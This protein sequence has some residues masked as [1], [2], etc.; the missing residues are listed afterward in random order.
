M[1]TLYW[2]IALALC[3]LITACKPEPSPPAGAYE[4]GVFGVNEG[5]FG[6]SSGTISYYNP[7]T[8]ENQGDIFRTQNGRFLGDVVQSLCFWG[9]QAYILVNNSQ[10]IEVVEANSFKEQA[11]VRGLYLPRYLC[12]INDS[13]AYISQWG[14]DGL[15]GSL[16]L[17]HKTQGL[18]DS[19]PLYQGPERL[20]YR[21]GRLYVLHAGGYDR[22]DKLAVLNTQ[23]QSLAAL[24]TPGENPNSLVFEPSGASFWLLCAGYTRYTTYPAIDTQASRP[25]RLLRMDAQTGQIYFSKDLPLGSPAK[26]LCVDFEGGYLYYLQNGLQRLS[27]TNLQAPPELWQAGHFY[28]LS[29]SE[30]EGLLYAA[31]YTYLERAQTLRFHPQTGLRD[32]FLTGVF[33]NALVFKGF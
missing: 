23:D 14:Q 33:C 12:P 16:R 18:L 7:E 13:L 6:Q 26:D 4:R 5:V 24:W 25:P 2:L 27:L 32:S 17:Y 20:Y 28:G 22:E 8:G 21:Q 1:T 31:R 29:R 15:S 9:E 11:Q 30:T 3:T 10:R 19:L